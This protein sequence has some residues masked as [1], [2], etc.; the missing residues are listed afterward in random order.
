M[1]Q[2]KIA[3]VIIARN[4]EDRLENTL[5]SVINQTFPPFRIICID[6]GS[7]D[8]TLQIIQSFPEIELISSKKQHTSYLGKKELASIINLGLE[9]IKNDKSIDYIVILGADTIL[10]KDYFSTLIEKMEQDDNLVIASGIIIGE[11][12]KVPRGSGRMVRATFWKKIGSLYP[13]NYGFE[14]YLVL[15]AESMGYVTKTYQDLLLETQRKTS[16]KYPAKLYQYYGMAMKSLGYTFT[17]SLGRS[18]LLM[19]KKPLGGLFLIFGYFSTNIEFYESELRKFVRDT[20]K[21]LPLRF[22]INRATGK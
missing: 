19:K 11:Y 3:I 10:P 6:D 17:Y 14:A 5:K 22:Y 8:N 7:T 18:L 21:N 9:Q 4:E 20:Q 16:S 15:K 1:P 12:S 2:K 13:V